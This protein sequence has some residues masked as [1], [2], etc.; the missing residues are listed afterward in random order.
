MMSDLFASVTSSPESAYGALPHAA[1]ASPTMRRCGPDP[2]LASLSARQAKER[3]LLTSGTCGP[4]S[5]ISSSNVRL[6]SLLASRLREQ[7]EMLGSTLYRLT[8]TQRVMPSGLRKPALRVSARRTSDP[9]TIGWPSCQARDW[10]GS[11]ILGPQDRGLKGSPLNEIVMNNGNG[12]GMIL[13]MTA[14][15]AGWPTAVVQD[16]N[17]AS[18]FNKAGRSLRANAGMMMLDV[19]RLASTG[20]ARLTACGEMLIGSDAGTR[21]GGQ[22]HPA[23]SLWL[24]LGPFAIAWVSCGE[25]V[26]LARSG[27]RKVSSARLSPPCELK[28]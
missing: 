7:T 18:S 4:P 16:A 17:C 28:P 22:L 21:N 23:H 24:M 14:Q 9:A 12:F 10:K 13:P 26:T 6:R 11:P 15:L 1:P 19:A 27:R 3:G 20:P 25:R 2:A 5:T 8:W